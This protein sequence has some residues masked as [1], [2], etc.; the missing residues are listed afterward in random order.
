MERACFGI[1]EFL[2]FLKES[3]VATSASVLQDS[4]V[5]H[6]IYNQLYLLLAM[7]HAPFHPKSGQCEGEKLSS[8][9]D[10]VG[11]DVIINCS[12]RG[13]GKLVNDENM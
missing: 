11:Y 10:L 1:Q 3:S 9:N 12:G 13:A 5:F 2:Q 8:L 4:L 7:T 6:Y